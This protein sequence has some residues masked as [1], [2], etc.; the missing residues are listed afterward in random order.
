MRKKFL[1]ATCSFSLF[2]YGAYYTAFQSVARAI[3]ES[4]HLQE[5]LLGAVVAMH[6]LGAIV[7]MILAGELGERI[8]KRVILVA[9]AALVIFGGILAAIAGSFAA[10]AAGVF[11]MGMGY[12]VNEGVFSAVVV[13][14]YDGRTSFVVNIVQTCFSVGALISPVLAARLLEN[15]LAWQTVFWAS[16]ALYALVLIALLAMPLRAANPPKEQPGGLV[17]LQLLKRPV[18]AI[19]MLMTLLYVG[20]E[21]ISVVWG[22]SYLAWSGM[23]MT[24]ASL[25]ASL[26]WA[27]MVPGRLLAGFRKAPPATVLQQHI[28]LSVLGILLIIF[29]PGTAKFAGFALLGFGFSAIWTSIFGIGIV[30]ANDHS[31][32][33][34]SMIALAGC[35]G[36]MLIPSVVGAVTVGSQALP[37]IIILAILLLMYACTRVTAAMIRRYR[38]KSVCA[39]EDIQKNC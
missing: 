19:C 24:Q 13:D 39:G 5:E 4:F 16:S 29:L 10:V 12:G 9:S 37:M 6:S 11:L 32:A 23:S 2:A 25:S 3:S 7:S 1:L 27:A 30:V 34:F 31:S 15:G 17:S 20:A 21:V 26:L 33:A 14:E 38:E 18:I 8:P 36:G 28:V 35:A 22:M